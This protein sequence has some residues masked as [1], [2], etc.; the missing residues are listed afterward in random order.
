MQKY[1]FFSHLILQFNAAI[2]TLTEQPGS[3][4]K[5]ERNI[6]KMNIFKFYIV[7]LYFIYFIYCFLILF[8]MIL[9]ST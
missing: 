4:G 8:F 1:I 5:G 2:D 3:V 6:E 9:T 7:S